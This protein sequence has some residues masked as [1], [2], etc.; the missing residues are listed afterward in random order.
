M[1]RLCKFFL[2]YQKVTT[3]RGPKELAYLRKT[4]NLG[5]VELIEPIEI[6]Q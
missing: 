5:K 4:R 1:E 2:G 3:L 6:Y